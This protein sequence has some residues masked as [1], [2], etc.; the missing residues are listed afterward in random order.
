M[1]QSV[2]KRLILSL[3]SQI[4]KV[5]YFY[6]AENTSPDLAVHEIRK[7]FK[8]MRALLKF[9]ADL[10]NS[11]SIEC[12]LQI[13]KYAKN[14]A[15][16]RESYVNIQLFDEI[17][18]KHIIISENKIGQV[19][20]KLLAKNKILIEEQF[21]KKIDLKS[22][23]NFINKFQENIKNVDFKKPSKKEI[24]NQL[25]ISFFKNY[26]IFQNYKT[27]SDGEYLHKF[28][29]KLKRLYY[30]FEFIKFQNP[31]YFE[32]KTEQ[33]HK[34]TEQ[35]GNDHD[36]YI[37]LKEIENEEYNFNNSEIL[38]IEKQIQHLRELK[39][40]KIT[41][42]LKQFFSDTPDVFNLK[43]EKIFKIS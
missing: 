13:N 31:K 6:T 14:L 38:L 27:C 30:Q 7:S 28:R 21:I 26:T 39:L 18:S 32:L 10:P 5:V 33:L 17:I 25:C 41:T 4:E 22:F 36:L 12:T 20:E 24:F 1:V 19:K 29:K 2:E 37:F 9:Y 40:L 35:L 3:Q 8:R 16:L 43:M 42:R 15:L 34:I 11:F 23:Q